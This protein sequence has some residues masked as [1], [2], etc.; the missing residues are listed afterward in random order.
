MGSKAIDFFREKGINADFHIVSGGINS[1]RFHPV[2]S[3]PTTDLIWTGRLVEVKRLDILLHAIKQVAKKFPEI[4]VV[5]VGDGKLLD[6]TRS[7]AIE[8]EINHNINF[9][10]HQN[11]IE[12]WLHNSKIFVLTSDSEGLSLSMM[13]AMM[14]SLPVVVSDVGDL[15]DLV[16]H[17]VNGYL[18]PRRS[19]DLFAECI[20][21]LLSDDQK[22]QEF[23]QAA[24]RSAMRYETQA[25]IQHWNNIIAG[26][27]ES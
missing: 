9:V 5:I 25:T 14:C 19:P 12:D 22:L 26:Y 1:E 8:L 4:K 21:E 6:E 23:S 18:V 27:R 7:L 15:S 2:Q 3:K 13:E 20:I 24:H 10:G 16:V 17:K 11:T